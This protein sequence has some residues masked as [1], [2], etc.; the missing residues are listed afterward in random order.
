MCGIAGIIAPKVDPTCLE[1]MLKAMAHRGPDDRGMEIIEPDQYQL[2]LGSTRLAIIDLSPAGHMPMVDKESGNIV[3]FNGE[4]YNFQQL[5]QELEARGERFRSRTDT[6]VIL[7]AYKHW[8]LAAVSRFRG[9]FAF[10]LWD[11]CRQELLLVR[12]RLGKKPLYYAIPAPGV[13]VFASE[14]RAIIASGLVPPRLCLDA[15]ETYLW[16]GFVV[17]PLTITGDCPFRTTRV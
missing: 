17:S 15:L 14:V 8:G 9:M 11:P 4:V 16:K 1:R 12:D 7:Q 13:F 10:A 5:R 3:V 2:G 6:E